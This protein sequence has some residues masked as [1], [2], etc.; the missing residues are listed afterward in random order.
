MYWNKKKCSSPE[1]KTLLNSNIRCIE[2]TTTQKSVTTAV[3]LNSNIRCIEIVKRYYKSVQG[4]MLNSNIRCIEIQQILLLLLFFV[5]LNSNIRCIEMRFRC[6]FLICT[7]SWIV[8]LDVLK[9]H[10]SRYNH[11]SN[12]RWIVTLDVLKYI[13]FSILFKAV[14]LNSNIRC[15]EISQYKYKDNFII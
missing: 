15:I 5:L 3:V 6:P 13:L 10:R 4:K 12:N 11:K 1:S 8:T 7:L 14:K 2:I 9:C